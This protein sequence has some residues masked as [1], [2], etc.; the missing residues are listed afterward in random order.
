MRVHYT[1]QELLYVKGEFENETSDVF[2]FSNSVFVF[3]VLQG[4]IYAR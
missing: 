3:V 2:D 4:D 1:I